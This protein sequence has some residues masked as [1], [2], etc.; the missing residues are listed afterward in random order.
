VAANLWDVTDKSIDQVSKRMM[1]KWGVFNGAADS[2]E[3]QKSDAT[4]SLVDALV[5][6][7]DECQ[8]PYLI[9]K[10]VCLGKE[11]TQLILLFLFLG[12]ST[13]VYGVPVYVK[14]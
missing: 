6:S 2:T 9:G 4:L 12:A 14:Q 3:I 5:L 8:L 1:E 13:V 7:R 11:D 10:S